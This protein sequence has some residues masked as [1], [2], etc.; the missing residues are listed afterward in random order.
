MNIAV[1]KWLKWEF[2]PFWFFYIPLYVKYL[3]MSIKS[4][5]MA[6][7]TAS[8]PLM[9]YGGFTDYSK[10]SVIKLIDKAFIP[11]GTLIS[12]PSVEE[13]LAQMEKHEIEYPIILK[14]DK[15]ERGFGVEKVDDDGALAQ[16]F[17]D[18]KGIDDLILQDYADMPVELGVMY[19]KK[20]SE[21]KGIISSIVI[22]E[23]LKIKGDGKKSFL[24]VI[25]T[26]ER[27]RFYKES[28]IEI[29]AD[30]LKSV[31]KIDQEIELMAIGNHCRGTM[32]LDGNHLINNQLLDVF[33]QIAKPIKGFHFGRFDLRVPS[34]EDLYKGKNIRIIELNGAA[35]EPAHIYDPEMSLFK[36][37]QHLF[38]HWQRLYEISIENHKN[39][40]P[41]NT[42]WSLYKA[43]K[44]RGNFKKT[45]NKNT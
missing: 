1:L 9:I 22:K 41:Y 4:G 35:S 36:A 43:L 21:Q 42:A 14:P 2:W 16:Y 6:F 20:E 31:P 33:D 32:F 28:L 39:G 25:E 12:N 26:D 23:F 18:K 40:V 15:G 13:V 19:S 45:I 38:G 8:N 29:Y 34:L 17:I 11:K 3:W 30:K 24:E 7:F 5:S 10:Y 37:Y 27:A 44:R